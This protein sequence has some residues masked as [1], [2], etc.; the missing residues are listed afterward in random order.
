MPGM[1]GAERHNFMAVRRL[2]LIRHAATAPGNGKLLVGSTDVPATETGLREV[3]RLPAVLRRFA[4]EAWY[5]SPHRRARQTAERL[6]QIDPSV[7][8][9]IVDR[10]L[11]EIDFGRWEMKSFEEIAAAEPE[12][13]RSWLEFDSFVF[14]GGE[15]IRSFQDRI[16]AFLTDLA[17]SGA[18]ETGI[19]THGGVI[20]VMICQVLGLGPADYLLFDVRPAAVTVIELFGERGVLAG[21]NM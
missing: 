19:V 2:L 14:P 5:C 9:F 3:H 18:G 6:R 21:L 11:Q 4:P 15:A 16:L 8:E 20:R 1:K 13:V 17:R 7:P 12:A 10:R